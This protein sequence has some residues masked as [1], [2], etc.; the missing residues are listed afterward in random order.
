M[1][2]VINRQLTVRTTIYIYIYIFKYL[3]QVHNAIYEVL[4]LHVVWY[5]LYAN[6]SVFN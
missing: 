3:I 1:D 5:Q 2:V 4:H 6:G